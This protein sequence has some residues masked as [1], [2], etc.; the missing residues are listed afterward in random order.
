[1]QIYMFFSGSRENQN[2]KNQ[3][4]KTAY[5]FI[6]PNRPL[7]NLEYQSFSSHSQELQKKQSHCDG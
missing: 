7:Q 5:D 4:K 6:R 3:H 1:M 2:C